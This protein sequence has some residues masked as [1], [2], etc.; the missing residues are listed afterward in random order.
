MLCTIQHIELIQS[1]E[2]LSEVINEYG[3]HNIIIT[4]PH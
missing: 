4:S 3:M 1:F 2:D